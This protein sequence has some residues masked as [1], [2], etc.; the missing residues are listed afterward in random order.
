MIGRGS[1]GRPWIAAAL[2]RALAG[3]EAL[4]EPGLSERFEIILAHLARSLKFYGEALGLR[5][6]RK[7][8][9]WYVEN[10]PLS[11]FGGNL[12]TRRME[13]ARLCQID[14][15]GALEAA[16]AALWTNPPLPIP[17]PVLI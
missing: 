17:G 12:L 9:G 16:L 2:D 5:V 4:A 10:A 8:L 7:H 14:R 13:K 6:F 15:A 11:L 1:Y 3:G